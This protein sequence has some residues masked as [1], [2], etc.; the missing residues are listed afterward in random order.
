MLRKSREYAILL[1][2]AVDNDLVMGQIRDHMEFTGKVW[3]DELGE[4]ESALVLSYYKLSDVIKG[5]ALG[6]YVAIAY[7]LYH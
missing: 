5:I 7:L 2:E 3:N 1:E 4:Q 6:E